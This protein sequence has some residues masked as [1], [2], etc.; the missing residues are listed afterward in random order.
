MEKPLLKHVDASEILVIINQTIAHNNL[1]LRTDMGRDN[2]QFVAGETEGLEK[3]R[4]II[5]KLEYDRGWSSIV[6]KM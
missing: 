4:T 2:N 6:D 1:R 5:K 3:L